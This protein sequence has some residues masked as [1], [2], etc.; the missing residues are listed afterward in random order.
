MRSSLIAVIV[1]AVVAGAF[2][3]LTEPVVSAQ[4]G[5][6]KS[7]AN[8]IAKP[9]VKKDRLDLNPAE[10]CLFARKG[11]S[12]RNICQ[13]RPAQPNPRPSQGLTV[14]VTLW[15]VALPPARRIADVTAIG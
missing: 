2:A 4:G 3:V 11:L 7:A 10:S 8:S 1:S 12:E 9:A 14:I 5:S 6:P 15:P 13:L